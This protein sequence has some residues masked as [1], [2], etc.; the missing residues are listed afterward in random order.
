MG[1]WILLSLA[2]FGWLSGI[3]LVVLPLDPL[4]L[5]LCNCCKCCSNCSKNKLI[6]LVLPKTNVSNVL[7][8]LCDA[9]LHVLKDLFSS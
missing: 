5:P 6:I 7:S 3:T 1:L 2:H 9:V 4:Y 8:A